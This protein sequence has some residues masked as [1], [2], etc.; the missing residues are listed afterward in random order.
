MNWAQMQRRMLLSRMGFMW[1][2]KSKRVISTFKEHPWLVSSL[3]VAMAVTLFFAVRTVAFAIY[4]SGPAHRDQTLQGWMTP[5]YVSKSWNVPHTNIEALFKS[6]ELP[7]ERKP[8]GRIA[9]ENDISL[10]D[11]TIQIEAVIATHRANQ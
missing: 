6:L 3:V 5:G 4:W 10:E 9:E 8:I 7:L 2:N 1:G 11:L